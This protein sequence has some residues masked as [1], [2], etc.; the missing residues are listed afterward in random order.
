MLLSSTRRICLVLRTHFIIFFLACGAIIGFW[1][2]T[3]FAQTSIDYRIP[4][5]TFTA[6]PTIIQYGQSTLLSWRST[7]TT[8]CTSSGDG[9]S[10]GWPSVRATS[11]AQHTPGLTTTQTY[12]MSCMGRG[13]TRTSSVTVTV[14]PPKVPI[15]PGIQ[16]TTDRIWAEYEKAKGHIAYTQLKMLE[17][18]Y[19]VV[20]T[21]LK[22]QKSS[23]SYYQYQSSYYYPPP[24]GYT[25]LDTVYK[26]P[27][28]GYSSGGSFANELDFLT[29]KYA[30]NETLQLGS[31]TPRRSVGI[32]VQDVAV[33]S[34]TRLSVKSHPWDEMIGRLDKKA[35]VPK[36]FSLVPIDDFLVYFQGPHSFDALEAALKEM[37]S[38]GDSFFDMKD[39][40]GIKK[41]IATRLGISDIARLESLAGEFVFVSEDLSFVPGTDYALIFA[42]EKRDTSDIATLIESG[43]SLHGSVGEYYVIAGSD[44]LF[45]RIKRAHEGKTRSMY[46]AKDA[47][48]ALSVL[49]ER[50]D[51][52]IYFSEDFILKLVG[53]E[54]RIN[55]GRR[56]EIL[57]KMNT[58]QYSVLAYKGITGAWPTSLKQIAQEGYIDTAYIEGLTQEGFSVDPDGRVRHKDWGT[59][60]DVRSISSVSI[61]KV[62]RAE[63]DRYDS[64]REGYQSFW[65]EFFD[66]IGIAIT[67]GDHIYFHTIILP[68]IDE[69]Q[70]QMAKS[71]TGNTPMPFDGVRAPLRQSPILFLSHF[72]FDKF[73]TDVLYESLGV[74]R[75]KGATAAAQANLANI[76]AW[77]EIYYDNHKNSYGTATT[78][79]G[80]GLF[81]DINITQ[82][83]KA[84]EKA[85]QGTA[86]CRATPQAYALSLEIKEAAAHFCIDSTG[87][88]A[89]T[90]S[91]IVSTVC[92]QMLTPAERTRLEREARERASA[93]NSEEDSEGQGT[94]TYSGGY[95]TH[96]FSIAPDLSI[97][98]GP[99]V[100]IFGSV[101]TQPTLTPAAIAFNQ[102]AGTTTTLVATTT[103]PTT[104][105][106]T[107]TTI[108]FSSTIVTKEKIAELQGKLIILLKQLVVL[109]TEEL[110]NIKK[111]I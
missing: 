87:V 49:D 40:I 56:S 45:Q 26:I 36:I 30:A 53:P 75:G 76:R 61:N 55:A 46:E 17:K 22:S 25:I 86:I 8:S 35:E 89:F 48:Y 63:A 80:G 15:P 98:N 78:S 79:C 106:T 67:V 110:Q 9:A 96:T 28:L 1:G 47:K 64:F 38:L 58:L 70:Y 33:S 101:N 11:G 50:R 91:S 42:P 92:G 29:G 34:I 57:P 95:S 73:V 60:Y 20:P 13:G 52:F 83:I 94:F 105:S 85:A 6:N 66:P 12:T 5:L 31:I 103:S 102:L 109:L 32:G 44:Q 93:G 82:G 59:L 81:A 7:D 65:R 37:V 39:V 88:A 41:E 69:S 71:F 24:E 2:S 62:T 97:G 10:W 68:L 72:N 108:N 4:N 14:L 16:S 90:K 74:A 19:G 111:T 104:S 77:A 43:K 107:T 3:A 100:G 54:Y 18:K 21:A 99:P 51:G 84:A 23:S 27:V